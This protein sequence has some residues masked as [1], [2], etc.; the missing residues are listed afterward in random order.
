M[1]RWRTPDERKTDV[2]TPAD[3]GEDL[4]GTHDDK[5]REHLT[6]GDW[7]VAASSTYGQYS[8]ILCRRAE[9]EDPKSCRGSA[10]RAIEGAQESMNAVKHRMGTM[11]YESLDQSSLAGLEF[12]S[13]HGMSIGRD[14]NQRGR[15]TNDE[16]PTTTTCSNCHLVFD[17]IVSLGST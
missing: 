7:T 4:K 13:Q 15:R 5:D 12:R 16:G 10:R 1:Q 6:R 2:T 8:G 17:L 9:P 11:P 3:A 14:S